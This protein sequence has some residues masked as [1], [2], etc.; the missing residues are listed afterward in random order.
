MQKSQLANPQSMIFSQRSLISMRIPS[1]LLT[2]SILLGASL[3]IHSSSLAQSLTDPWSEPLNLSR[4]GAASDPT[5]AVD[6]EGIVHVFW[7]DEFDGSMYA[8]REG[9]EWG[10][11][12]QVSV[13]FEGFIS[14]LLAD[15]QGY[16]HAFWIDEEQALR[17]AN[18]LISTIPDSAWNQAVVIT[19][20]AAALDVEIDTQDRLHLTYFRVVNTAET[21]AGIYYRRSEPGGGGWNSSLQLYQSLYFRTLSPA[22][23]HVDID[24]ANPGN[25]QQIF[26]TWDNRPR[27]RVYLAKS[28]DGGA[29]WAE[30]VEIDKPELSGE[31]AIPSSLTV[32]AQ[33]DEVL[34]VWQT[35]SQNTGCSQYYQQS[36]DGGETWQPPQRFSDIFFGCV[37][38]FYFLTSQGEPILLLDSPQV[39]LQAWDGDR[40]SDPRM[41]SSLNSFIDPETQRTV[42]LVCLNPVLSGDELFVVGCTTGVGGDDIWWLER[43]LSD[44]ADWFP[45]EPVWQPL[46]SVTRGGF[47]SISLSLV[48]DS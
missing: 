41:Q 19:D 48:V 2:I 4:S 34:L 28:Q 40:W 39:Y 11:P 13:P 43:N 44:L 8:R 20:S 42:N 15:S 33:D 45:Q 36:V 14:L 10:D 26:I 29:T 35:G 38:W 37:E 12:I 5:V 21:P 24:I 6:A 27:S 25:A 16:L 9:G 47:T 1:L 32:Y 23:A 46:N 17:Y 31:S 18:V 7:T 30:P 3:F 22:Q